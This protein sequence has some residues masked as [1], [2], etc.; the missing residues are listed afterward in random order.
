MSHRS[1]RYSFFPTDPA[2]E[3]FLNLLLTCEKLY[4][5]PDS[6]SMK[7]DK[8]KFAVMPHNEREFIKFVLGFFNSADLLVADNLA[9]RFLIDLQGEREIESLL[10]FQLMMENIHSR[11]Y[12]SMINILID[13]EKE[14]ADCFAAIEKYEP[15]KKKF[16]Y[17]QKWSKSDLPFA[18]RAVAFTCIE[19]IF[20][21][22]AFAAIFWAGERLPGVF[23]ANEYIRRD[24]SYHVITGIELYKKYAKERNSD[25]QQ[26][27]INMIKE[28]AEIE[29]EFV[30]EI[31]KTPLRGMNEGL[32][33]DYVEVMADFLAVQLC[34][35]KIYKTENPFP[36]ML[37]F[38]MSGKTNFFEARPTQYKND[39]ATT[40]DLKSGTNLIE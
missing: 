16:E 22:S 38:E 1:I 31:L 15:I 25:Y 32:L 19:C 39:V 9:S 34:G 29:K 27:V 7:D 4:W 21:C 26:T 10:G 18:L 37:S 40:S 14:R 30:T 3:V 6:V 13:D 2:N 23:Q 17:S 24:E 33:S 8:E 35:K 12:S 28:A 20:F 5:I 36:R 11:T